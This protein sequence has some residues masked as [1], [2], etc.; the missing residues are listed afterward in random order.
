MQKWQNSPFVCSLSHGDA[1]P[2]RCGEDEQGPEKTTIESPLGGTM[3]NVCE[4]PAKLLQVIWS[5]G[6]A[7]CCQV[8]L[9]FPLFKF[10][11]NENAERTANFWENTFPDCVAI[12]LMKYLAECATVWNNILENMEPISHSW[13]GHLSMVAYYNSPILT[14]RLCGCSNVGFH[15]HWRE[16]FQE[17]KEIRIQLN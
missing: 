16:S 7:R 12:P 17:H 14:S 9:L 5:H 15:A 6:C 1:L 3:G 8:W 2:D 13:I 11:L 4:L 10:R